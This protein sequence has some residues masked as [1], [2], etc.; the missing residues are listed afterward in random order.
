MC[1]R[2]LD[3]VNKELNKEFPKFLKLIDKKE[4]QK[5]KKKKIMKHKVWSLLEEFR[6]S[7]LYNRKKL[8][9]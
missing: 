2:D 9:R 6:K 4:S 3:D 7:C 1:V 8:T 5:T